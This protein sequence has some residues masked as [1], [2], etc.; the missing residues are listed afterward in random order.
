[1]QFGNSRQQRPLVSTAQTRSQT[2]K[3]R[4]SSPSKRLANKNIDEEREHFLKF[5]KFLSN[6]YIDADMLQA[7]YDYEKI[8]G[9]GKEPAHASVATVTD[10]I[11]PISKREN[12]SQDIQMGPFNVQRSSEGVGILDMNLTASSPSLAEGKK[13]ALTKARL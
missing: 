10:Q 12:N 1:M 6:I 3:S 2:R 13:L 5:A 4:S 7:L 9:S 11:G 8:H